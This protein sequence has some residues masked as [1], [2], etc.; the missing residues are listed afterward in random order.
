MSRTTEEEIPAWG[1]VEST[2]AFLRPNRPVE[3][4]G[5]NPR[6]GFRHNE[7]LG[8]IYTLNFEVDEMTWRAWA[9][10][11]KTASLSLVTWW[12]EGNE[13]KAPKSPAP[14][15]SPPRMVDVAAV[16]K[17]SPRKPRKGENGA[18]WN[19]LVKRGFWSFPGVQEAL[20]AE[21]QK[22]C[23]AAMRN[24]FNT[25]TLA[26]VNAAE[27]AAWASKRKLD[28]LLNLVRQVSEKLEE[29]AKTS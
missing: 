1:Q 17:P 8:D 15:K 27:L 20:K 3:I 16:D 7:T 24:Q 29:R 12:N 18:L 5:R 26:T 19:S 28:G 4:E 25:D 14:K 2:D 13:E 11:P 9:M 6:R 22:D 10:I 23:L 21:G